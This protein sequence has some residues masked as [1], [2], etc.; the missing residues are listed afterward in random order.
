MQE[1]TLI[2]MLR[3]RASC[4]PEQLAYTFLSDG[5][6]PAERLTY[7]ELDARA[8][9]IAAHLQSLG[10]TGERALL[11]YPAGLDFLAGFFGCLYAGVI[12]IPAPPPEAS[13]MKRTVPRLQAIAKDAQAS[14]VLTTSKLM[15]MVKDVG[16]WR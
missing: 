12:A 9:A 7:G 6:V 10:G 4:Y 1:R 2:D 3:Q 15:G 5:T 14:L 16:E 8:R 13:R 11:L